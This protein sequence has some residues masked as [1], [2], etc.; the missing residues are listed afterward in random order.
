VCI[1]S[2][3]FFF[4]LTDFKSAV[5]ISHPTHQAVLSVYLNLLTDIAFV[6]MKRKVYHRGKIGCKVWIKS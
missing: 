4:L 1:P 3:F 5:A 6:Q 2:A